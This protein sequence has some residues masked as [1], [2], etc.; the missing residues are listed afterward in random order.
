MPQKI[1]LSGFDDTNGYAIA[2]NNTET[3]AGR[4]QLTAH[5]ALSVGT[6]KWDIERKTALIR[7]EG[8]VTRPRTRA[9]ALSLLA[10]AACLLALRACNE[11]LSLLLGMP[12][13]AG[14][15]CCCC[16]VSGAHYPLSAS[17]GP[18]S[19]QERD[20]GT[21]VV[22]SGGKLLL[23]MPRR[24]GHHRRRRHFRRRHHRHRAHHRRYRR[25]RAA[26]EQRRPLRCGMH[27][28]TN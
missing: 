12:T 21:R 9:Y 19:A 23:P 25:G 27:S 8:P 28:L 4:R 14:R 20:P 1:F 10:F 22:G 5:R 16:L 6:V 13:A 15:V 18:Q 2:E 3:F 17:A 11:S 24:R 7:I 26:L